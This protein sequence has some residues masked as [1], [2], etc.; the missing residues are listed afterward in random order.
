[1][2][3]WPDL[4]I[5]QQWIDRKIEQK[6]VEILTFFSKTPQMSEKCQMSQV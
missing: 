3:R 1:M 6:N 2:I 4:F 5:L